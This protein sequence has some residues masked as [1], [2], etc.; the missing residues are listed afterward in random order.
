MTARQFMALWERRKLHMRVMN[1]AAAHIAAMYH[2]AHGKE[3]HPAP[4]EF[5]PYY[6]PPI[7]SGSELVQKFLALGAKKIT[8]N[9]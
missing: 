4:A 6:E 5:M 9:E 2:G 7:I 3:P 8:P 1:Y